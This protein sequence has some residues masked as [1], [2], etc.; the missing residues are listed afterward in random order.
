ME[1]CADDAGRPLTSGGAM[2]VA[3]ATPR[4]KQNRIR[5][6]ARTRAR[7]ATWAASSSLSV[8]STLE[9]GLLDTDRRGADGGPRLGDDSGANPAPLSACDGFARPLGGGVGVGARAF[10]RRAE[11]G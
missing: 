6:A 8:E 5:S 11:L 9:G 7:R 2:P 3:P 4:R 1:P 10:A